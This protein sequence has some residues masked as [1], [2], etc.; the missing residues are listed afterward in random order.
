MQTNYN[1][2]IDRFCSL[3]HN[4]K[5]RD[6]NWY[7]AMG[8][9]IGGSEI[10]AIMGL[11]PYSSFNSVVYSKVEILRTGTCKKFGGDACW[12]G[13]IFEDIIGEYISIDIGNV[14]K[15][16]NIC[17]QEFPGHRNSPDG[18][19]VA[20]FYMDDDKQVLWTTDMAND[21]STFQEILLLEF[22]C[23]LSRKPTGIIPVYYETQLLSGLMV[24]PLAHCGMFVDAL[25][26]KSDL[27]D[28]EMGKITNSFDLTYHKNDKTIY[29]NPLAWGMIAVYAPEMDAP[30]NI[31]IKESCDI[32]YTAWEMHSKYFREPLTYKRGGNNE[33]IDF[34]D[35]D[36]RVFSSVLCLIDNG[37]FQIKRLTPQFSDGRGMNYFPLNK[38]IEK[39]ANEPPE[40][41]WLLGVI[42]WKL[43]E[44]HYSFIER[45]FGFKEKVMPLIDKV[46][47]AVNEILNGQCEK[48]IVTCDEQDLF[49]DL[50]L[51]ATKEN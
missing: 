11:N 41:Y 45:E 51:N 32:A 8:S 49:D 46:H 36:N 7:T 6:K 50:A 40:N 14:L 37:G 2:L 10:A 31:R 39:I 23:P 24:S 19:I 35:I 42:P 30:K 43:F 25:F 3:Y 12:W 16:D 15:G 47:V 44:L 4:I 18:Y 1:D 13:I 26:R 20:N 21:K 22:K 48:N 9:T 34:G 5:Q 38:V 29:N 33:I 17:I 28:F 27:F